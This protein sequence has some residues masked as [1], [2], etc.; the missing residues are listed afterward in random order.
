MSK[1]IK[2]T[3]VEEV[4]ELMGSG[5]VF[6]DFFAN[7]CEPCKNIAPYIEEIADSNEAVKVLKVDIELPGMKEYVKS[8]GVGS[9]PTIFVTKDGFTLARKSGAMTKQELKNLVEKLN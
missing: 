5:A 9:I 1:V 6:T 8:L 7:W 4:K 3:T 2:P